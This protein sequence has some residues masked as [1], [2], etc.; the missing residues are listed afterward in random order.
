[1]EINKLLEELNKIVYGNSS[2]DELDMFLK[3]NQD[4]LFL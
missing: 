1:M 3:N 4:I 2:V